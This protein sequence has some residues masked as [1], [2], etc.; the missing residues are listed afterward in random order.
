[1]AKKNYSSESERKK[2]SDEEILYFYN[3]LYEYEH[4]AS[5]GGYKQEDFLKKL[6]NLVHLNDQYGRNANITIL[7]EN[8]LEFTP[9]N[10]NI[11]WAILYH[12]RN[13]I[14]HGNLYSTNDDNSFLILDYWDKE[15]RTKCS[16]SGLIEKDKL[17]QMIQLIKNTRK[18]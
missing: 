17:Y 14:A 13:S 4:D 15:K 5:H 8:D 11:C 2:L 1:M 16:M 7:N 12:I 3:I 10:N 6:D 9:Y 18:P